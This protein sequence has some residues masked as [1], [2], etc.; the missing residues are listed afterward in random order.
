MLCN[1]PERMKYLY[2]ILFALIGLGAYAQEELTP[3]P[4][5]PRLYHTFPARPLSAG[6]HKSG[7]IVQHGSFLI[8]TDTLS[9]PFIDDFSYNTLK[10]FHFEQYIY[11]TIYRTYGPCDSVMGVS[12]DTVRLSTVQSY[13][14]SY[15]LTLHQVDSTPTQPIVFHYYPQLGTDC[16]NYLADSITLYPLW[17]HYTFDS[18]GNAFRPVLDSIAR[19]TVITY[20]A[21]LLRAKM[22]AYTKWLDNY[23]THNYNFPYLPPSIGVATLDGLNEKGRPYDITSQSIYRS[24]DTL[25]SKPLDLG[26]LG[27]ADSVYLSFYYEAR[28]FGDWPNLY[29]SLKLQFYN[30]YTSTWDQVWGIPGYQVVPSFPDTFRQVMI[31]IPTTIL[32]TQLYMYKGFQFR[33]LNNASSTGM[34]DHWH[35]D[36]VRLDKN[37]SVTDTS[38]NDIAF[39][40]QFP[41]IL[42][43]Y[44]ELPAWQYDSTERA[45]SIRLYVT[46]LNP[47]QAVNNPPATAYSIV[48]TELYPTAQSTYATTSSFNATLEN[49]IEL[50]PSTDYQIAAGPDST[51]V[52]SLATINVPNALRLNDT[53]RGTQTLNNVL[54]Y[55]DG[56]AEMAYGL[57]NLYLKKFGYEFNLHQP[58]VIVG[59]QVMFTNTEQD[60]HDLVF[61]FNLWDSISL[62]NPQ[63]DDTPR[64]TS[65]NQIPLYVDSVS[66][67]ATYRIDPLPVGTHFYF[68]WSQTDTRNLQIGYD[69]NSTKGFKHMYVY[70][71]GVWLRTGVQTQGSPMIRLLM[72]RSS[73]IATGIEQPQQTTIRAYPNPATGLVHFE[74]PDEHGSYQLQLY[75]ATGQLCMDQTLGS[76][77]T[78]DIQGLATGVY[79]L[80]LTDLHTGIT[81]QNKI[82]KADQ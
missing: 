21:M 80:R 43:N 2:T 25:T 27:D 76:S 61:L 10:P 8:E 52:T 9:I 59:Y 74:V 69:R 70:S 44:S 53:I 38:I 30:G 62:N 15:D 32:P 56:T 64:Y 75:S 73:Q 77:H 60:V 40:Y 20:S 66:G 78:T 24:A 48:A 82:V 45:D 71:N 29:D 33:F 42:K 54:A 47:D 5:D 14:Y 11:D 35:I 67:Y 57:R 7:L 49:T 63:A 36:Y 12:V 17:Y 13:T 19:D 18:A 6:L 65:N 41:S 28:G 50:F 81:Y 58:D 4:S 46:N 22:P 79:M 72:R 39:Q 51:V 3:L 26:G 68:G 55:D 31:R 23:A 37:R 1:I 34:N 16:F